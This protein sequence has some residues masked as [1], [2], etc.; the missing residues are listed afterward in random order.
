MLAPRSP[1]SP[2]IDGPTIGA[3]PSRTATKGAS[4][5]ATPWSA[6]VA[7]AKALD[8]E[9]QSLLERHLRLEPEALARS[10][11]VEVAS[12]LPVRTGMVPV[13]LSFVPGQIGD[14]GGEVSNGGLRARTDVHGLGR[15]S[16]SREEEG[17]GRV[18]DVEELA[19]GAPLPHSVTRSSPL[20]TASTYFRTIAATTCESSRS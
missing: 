3:L 20:S 17:P 6:A 7:R 18:V 15:P 19:R 8:R 11:D 10:A 12:R 16:L 4:P 2:A 1:P 5:I 9:P 13:G 14:Q